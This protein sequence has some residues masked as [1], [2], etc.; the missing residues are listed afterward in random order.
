MGSALLLSRLA[1]PCWLL[2]AALPLRADKLLHN[3]SSRMLVL[4]VTGQDLGAAAIKIQ[5]HTTGRTPKTEQFNI[6]LDVPEE[7]KV[8]RKLFLNETLADRPDPKL[9]TLTSGTEPE[10][11]RPVK[12]PP[13][14]SVS[15]FPVLAA[16]PLRPGTTPQVTL[17]VHSIDRVSRGFPQLV[18]ERLSLNYSFAVDAAGAVSETLIGITQERPKEFV[19]TLAFG[20][21]TDPIA[22]V[23]SGPDRPCCF[24]Q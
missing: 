21:D 14:C 22:L 19:A 13:G 15:F 24:I 16:S 7:S 8:E 9:I 3:L 18:P 23:D 4:K 10:E 17:Q 5:L 1:L 12:L 2:L 6:F 20:S 11:V